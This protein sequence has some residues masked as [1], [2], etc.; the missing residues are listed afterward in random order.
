LGSAEVMAAK[1]ERMQEFLH[2]LK[3]GAQSGNIVEGTIYDSILKDVKTLSHSGAK[4]TNFF[5][6]SG[7]I[8]FEKELSKVVASILSR[9]SGKALSEINMNNINIGSKM[10][11]INMGD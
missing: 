8:A 7:G 3:K 9:A 1:A 2:E 6:R 5:R 10:A 11:N 4:M